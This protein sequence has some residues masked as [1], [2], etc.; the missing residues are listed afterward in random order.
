MRLETDGEVGRWAAVEANASTLGI[1][2]HGRR[3][4]QHHQ[5][6]IGKLD[7]SLGEW[8]HTPGEQFASAIGYSHS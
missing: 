5:L 3:E 4:V 7:G 6:A 1:Y 2:I 8:Y